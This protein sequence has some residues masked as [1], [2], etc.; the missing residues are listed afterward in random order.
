MAAKFYTV[1]KEIG[2][3]TYTAQF[4]GI[5]AALRAID[6]S[7]ID[8]ST[9]TSI[10]KLSDYIFKHVIVNP[11]GLSADDFDNMD[12]LNE[13]VSFGRDVMQ[14]NFRDKAVESKAK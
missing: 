2:G 10:A 11:K 3:V 12:D 5:S 1:E 13:V 8:G 7:Y 9:N 14:G 4:S 6:D